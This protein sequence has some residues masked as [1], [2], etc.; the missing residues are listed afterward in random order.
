MKKIISLVL[1]MMLVLTMG[2]VAFADT[3]VYTPTV[4]TTFK[5][6]VKTYTSENNVVV[7]ETLTFTSTAKTTNPDG[8]TA[9][10]TVA[11]LTVSSLNPGALTVTIPSLSVAGKYEWVIKENAGK[12][13]GVTYSTDEVHVLVLVEYDNV[14]KALKIANTTSYIMGTEGKNDDGTPVVTKKK[15]FTNTFK[16]GSFTVAKDVEGNMSNLNDEFSIS[17]VLTSANKPGT[18]MTVAGDVI[19]PD[20]WEYMSETKVWQYSCV[21]E[22]SEAGGLKTFSDIPVGVSVTVYE[23]STEPEDINGYTFEGIYIGKAKQNGGVAEL[24]VADDTIADITV[25]NTNESTIITGV[26]TE[27]LP[28]IVLIGVVALVGAAMI[29]RRRAY[30]G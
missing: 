6:I 15:D 8:G 18:K 27:S 23:T 22:Y 2:A 3:V 16:S 20:A 9:N 17:V 13:P 30:N 10:L 7:N 19:G 24:T 4:A 25:K 26:S 12:T 11:N 1:A 5:E 29:I 28:Y 21:K 14:T